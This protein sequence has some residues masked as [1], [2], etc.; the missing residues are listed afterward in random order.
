MADEP[1]I[2]QAMLAKPSVA[3]VYMMKPANDP[4]FQALRVYNENITTQAVPSSQEEPTADKAYAVDGSTQPMCR[5][6]LRVQ[7]LGPPL[8][9]PAVRF[10]RQ[11]DGLHL[12]ITLEEDPS[13]RAE[14]AIPFTVTVK[15]VQLKYGDAPDQ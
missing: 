5:P 3:S 4:V 8:P 12:K 6:F 9:S 11:D 10:E 1:I 7:E 2:A 15:A 13:R 14:G